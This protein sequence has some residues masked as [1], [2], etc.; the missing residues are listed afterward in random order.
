MAPLLSRR[1][2]LAGTAAS[3]AAGRPAQSRA[4]PLR[5]VARPARVNLVGHAYPDTD[6]W[7]YDGSVPGPVIRAR[8]G[9]TLR[10]EVENGLAEPTTVHWHGI[11]LPNAMDGVPHLT[12][13]PI[14]PGG[15]FV[16]EFAPPDAGTFWYHPHARSFEQVARG[17]HGALIVEEPMPPAVDRDEVWVLADWRLDRQAR[18]VED[19]G[20]PRDLSHDGRIGNTVTINGRVPETFVLR[21]GERLRL[22]LVNAASAR[23]FALEFR[24][25]RPVIVA[26]DGQPVEPHA[27]A[28]G[29]IVLA[30]AE[31]VDLILD[32]TGAPHDRATVVDGGVRERSYR[33]VDLV[34]APL[35]L[36][37]RPPD[38]PV[39]LPDNGLP[40]PDLGAAVRHEI[41]FAGGA[42]GT[43]SEAV[44]DGVRLDM[45]A[46]IGRG[47][48]WAVN[49]VS[50][51]EHDGHQALDPF[52]TLRRGASCVLAMRNDTAW[53]HPIHL[54]GHSF[55]VLARD[56]VPNPR[57]EWR[58]TVLMRP[59]EAVDIAFVADN[60]GDWMFHCHILDHQQAGMM[61]HLRV[62]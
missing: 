14:G 31:R 19:F 30:P 49:G 53:P 41:V 12:Q 17:L 24:G 8:R 4:G 9:E 56:G 43:M 62:L 34:Y 22:R 32:A 25:H 46:L 35:P 36:R 42:M 33:L 40:E 13:P 26:F 57:R 20:N 37:P 2:F 11:R 29:R 6:V 3:L 10:V 28:D 23:I 59:R 44:L 60:P 7:A 39:R 51:G 45:R 58:D 16:Y 27:P 15:R 52:L 50:A 47:K 1:R 5:L 55:R 48:A 38:E 21:A 61:A 54:H 18:L